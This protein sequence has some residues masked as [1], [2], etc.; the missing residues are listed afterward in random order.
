[1][2]N[3]GCTQSHSGMLYAICSDLSITDATL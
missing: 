3:M 2:K 1:L